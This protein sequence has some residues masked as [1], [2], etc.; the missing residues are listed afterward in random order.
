MKRIPI[1]LQA[2]GIIV[3]SYCGF[4]L[5]FDYILGQVIPASLLQMYMF[6]I[7]IGVLA[8]YTATEEGAQRLLNPIKAMVEDPG[9]RM[10]RN[11]VFAVVPLL[12]GFYIYQQTTPSV[13]APV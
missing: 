11:L 4:I 7:I 10:I 12:A 5:L 13:E 1:L 6:F 3:L 8:V 2:V 9:N